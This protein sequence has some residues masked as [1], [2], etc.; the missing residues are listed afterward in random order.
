MALM[1]FYPM[2]KQ[3]ASYTAT[4]GL[5]LGSAATGYKG[6][7]DYCAD[8]DEVAYW[9]KRG[10]DW[11]YGR[12]VFATGT[13]AFTRDNVQASSTGGIGYNPLTL[14]SGE[15][16]TVSCAPQPAATPKLLFAATV[17]N[18][19]C[20]AATGGSTTYI[21]WNSGTIYADENMLASG[22]SIGMDNTQYKFARLTVTTKWPTATG[23][24]YRYTAATY[25]STWNSTIPTMTTTGADTASST[26]VTPT[27]SWNEM[28]VRVEHDATADQSVSMNVLIEGW[29]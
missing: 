23:A 15:S 8:G 21:D 10:S 16:I 22:G 26:W 29:S 28:L 9:L 19:N 18:Y 1:G 17:S 14:A 12:G 25:R 6:F 13:A 27:A 5:V 4:G 20:A 3:D 24:T 11:E 2:V 7:G